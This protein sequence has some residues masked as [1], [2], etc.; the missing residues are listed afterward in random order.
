MPARVARPRA[1][2][3]PKASIGFY[4]VAMF[5]A[6][7]LPVLA[8]AALLLAQLQLNERAGLESRTE[9]EA[10]LLA[11]AVG[12]TLQEMTTTLQVLVTSPELSTGDLEAFHNRAQAAL[13]HGSLFVILVD[14]DGQQLL[15]TRVPYGTSLG[16]TSNMTSL[17]AALQTGAIQVSDVFYGATSQ[18]WVFNVIIPLPDDA[19]PGRGALIITKNAD[20]LRGLINADGLPAG[21]TAA[22]I[23]SA[24]DVV[25]SSADTPLEADAGKARHFDQDLATQLAATSGVAYRQNDLGSEEVVGYAPLRDSGWKAVVWGPTVA[26]QASILTTWEKLIF[27]STAL[28]AIAIA[29]AVFLAG[30]LRVTIGGLAKMAEDVGDG[31]R[32]APIQS[33]IAEI[34]RVARAL[35]AASVDRSHAEDQIRL[36]LGELAHRTKNQ[37]AVTQAIIN[38]T[39]R[40]SKGIDEFKLAIT[41]RIAGL[42]RSTDLLTETQWAGVPVKNVVQSHLANFLASQKQLTLEGEDFELKPAAV[43]NLG[44]VLHELG[45]NATKHGA[46]SVASGKVRI[47]WHIDR[48]VAAAPRIHLSWHE[49]G[50]PPPAAQVEKGFGSRILER[51]AAASFRGDVSLDFATDENGN[52]TFTWSIR[53]PFSAFAETGEEGTAA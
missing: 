6:V 22:V 14:E 26:A 23:D 51:H 44:L 13:R 42:G 21:W 28:L 40:H 41:E 43:Q 17:E 27:G 47:A 32:V 10:Q 2:R 50:G 31:R 48:S 30:K 25:V 46:L 8:F 35:S 34:D 16:K 37:L 3:A 11:T 39:S 18:R 29:A 4:L 7:T 19:A 20:E 49:S 12:H 52:G 45:T 33:P 1:L 5:C 38:Q 9:R 15:N 24:G 53:A 36:M